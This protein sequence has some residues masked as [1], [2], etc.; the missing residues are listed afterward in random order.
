LQIDYKVEFFSAKGK[1]ESQQLSGDGHAFQSAA[2]HFSVEGN[3]FVDLRMAFQQACAAGGD[4]PTDV[5][6]GPATAKEI[7]DGQRV[8]HIA[9]GAG[10]DDQNSA[11]GSV[12]LWAGC[13]FAEGHLLPNREARLF[14]M[15]N[16]ITNNQ[17]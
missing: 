2:E 5:R 7:Q 3:Q 8:N 10:F 6:L 12:E 16:Q 14:A 13:F 15:L 11:R 17:T 4:E 9:D 1:P